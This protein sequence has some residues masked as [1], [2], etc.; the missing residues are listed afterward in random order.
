[1]SAGADV[2]LLSGPKEKTGSLPVLETFGP[3]IPQQVTT[4]EE[5]VRWRDEFFANWRPER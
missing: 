2:Y 4:V 5:Q 1:M 3:A